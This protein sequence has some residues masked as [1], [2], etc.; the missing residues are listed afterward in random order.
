MTKKKC[1]NDAPGLGTRCHHGY[2]W[3]LR[4]T[5]KMPWGK[6]IRVSRCPKCWKLLRVREYAVN[7]MKGKKA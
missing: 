2:L 7:L 5:T 4:Y 6:P 3:K 1:V